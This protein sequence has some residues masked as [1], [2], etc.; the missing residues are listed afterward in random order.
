MEVPCLLLH[1]KRGR[2]VVQL[3]A[4]LIVEVGAKPATTR[5]GSLLL[6][7]FDDDRHARQVLGESLPTATLPGPLR[8]LGTLGHNVGVLRGRRLVALLGEESQLVRVEA[9]AARAVLLTQQHVHRVFELLDPPLSLVERVRLLAD[10]LVT[11]SNVVGEV[12]LG[13]I[14]G[15]I[16]GTSTRSTRDQPRKVRNSCGLADIARS[17]LDALEIDT[18]EQ[19]DQ[20]GRVD[21]HAGRFGV[22]RSRE[23]EGALFQTFEVGI[24]MPSLLWRYRN[25]LRPDRHRSR[26]AG[27]RYRGGRLLGTTK[28][29]CRAAIQELFPLASC[30]SRRSSSLS[31]QT[32]KCFPEGVRRE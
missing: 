10:Q 24:T 8:L 22:A 5:A 17:S 25:C 31:A 21:R 7:E 20:V 19:H 4:D 2:D 18:I 14:H 3:L 27:R 6:G 32:I 15:D 26:V 16:V 9:F 12:D 11:E 13:V 29:G 30:W 28:P 1:E 23:P